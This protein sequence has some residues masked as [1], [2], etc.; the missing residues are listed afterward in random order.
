MHRVAELLLIELLSRHGHYS[1]GLLN[2]M[3]GRGILVFR[4]NLEKVGHVVAV[5]ACPGSDE[6]AIALALFE[7][8]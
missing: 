1:L 3:H 5:E 4:A 8:G 6:R 7:L 2:E